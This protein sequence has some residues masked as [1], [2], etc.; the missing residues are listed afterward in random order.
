MNVSPATIYIWARLIEWQMKA[1][2]TFRLGMAGKMTKRPYQNLVPGERKKGWNAKLISDVKQLEFRMVEE[3]SDSL[4][5]G[6][7]PN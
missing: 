6:K 3:A 2:A 1:T 5:Y 4:E 7:F